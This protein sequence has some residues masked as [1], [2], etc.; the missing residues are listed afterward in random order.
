MPRGDAKYNPLLISI[1]CGFL[2]SLLASYICV[3]WAELPNWSIGVISVG[4][5]ALVLAIVAAVLFKSR[6]PI[7]ETGNQRIA[8]G[9]EAGG[10]VKISNI[11]VSGKNGDSAEIAN[12]IKAKKGDVTISDV[13]Y[14]RD[15]S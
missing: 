4:I 12:D 1:A 8:S 10:N 2:S 7:R 14:R 15:G 3:T 13:T 9:V 5:G 6:A 11:D